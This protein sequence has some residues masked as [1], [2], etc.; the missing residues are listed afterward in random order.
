MTVSYS[1]FIAHD[2]SECFQIAFLKKQLQEETVHTVN[3][4]I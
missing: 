3:K 4:K 1:E 2:T